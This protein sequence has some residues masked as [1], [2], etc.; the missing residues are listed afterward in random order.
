MERYHMEFFFMEMYHGVD[1]HGNDLGER[2]IKFGRVYA[3]HAI[4]LA[5]RSPVRMHEQVLNFVSFSS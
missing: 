1:R 2:M 4:F 5:V 3:T